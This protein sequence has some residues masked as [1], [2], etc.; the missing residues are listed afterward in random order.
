MWAI[1]IYICICVRCLEIWRVTFIEPGTKAV[2]YIIFWLAMVIPCPT[3]LYILMRNNSEGIWCDRERWDYIV[4]CTHT[5]WVYAIFAMH[6][7]VV[8]L[9]H[10]DRLMSFYPF[11]VCG[12]YAVFQYTYFLSFY[13]PCFTRVQISGLCLKAWFA[14]LCGCSSQTAGMRAYYDSIDWSNSVQTL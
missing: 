1:Y 9:P 13:I 10:P 6:T 12:V 3:G 7:T 5:M 14:V 8:F 11:S 2:Q 4:K